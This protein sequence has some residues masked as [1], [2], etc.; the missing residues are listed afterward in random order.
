MTGTLSWLGA[1]KTRRTAPPLI[2]RSS[3]QARRCC[4]CCCSSTTGTTTD[5]AE[6]GGEGGDD[7]SPCPG[8]PRAR[9]SATILSRPILDVGSPSSPLCICF[10]FFLGIITLHTCTAVP[11]LSLICVNYFLHS[12]LFG[13][14]RSSSRDPGMPF[15]SLLSYKLHSPR[16]PSRGCRH[17]TLN[18]YGALFFIT[19]IELAFS[20][21]YARCG[22]LLLCGTCEC[23]SL[24]CFP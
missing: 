13:V 16:L 11:L 14:S 10:F 17:T 6:R 1:E 9:S 15:L 8:L 3:F 23:L 5:V 19:K 21:A 20:G 18:F 22:V 12:F 24:V 7:T 2:G 4:Y